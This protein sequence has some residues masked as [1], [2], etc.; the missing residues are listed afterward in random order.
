MESQPQN[1]EFMINPENLHPC[2]YSLCNKYIMC[3]YAITLDFRGHN[4]VHHKMLSSA[5]Y[6]YLLKIHQN[7]GNFPIIW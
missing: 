5:K 6:F 3:T 4:L 7:Q 2:S 1:P